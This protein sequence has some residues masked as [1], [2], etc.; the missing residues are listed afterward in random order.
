[1]K[2]RNLG[3]QNFRQIGSQQ[4]RHFR[5]LREDQGPLPLLR[6]LGQDLDEARQLPGPPR[7][8]PAGGQEVLGVVADLLEAG[9]GAQDLPSPRKAGVAFDPLQA[10]VHGRLVERGLLDG[11]VAI[12]PRLVFLWQIADDLRVGLEPAQDERPDEPA[13]FFGRLRILGAFHGGRERPP[14]RAFGTEETRVQDLHDGP[15]VGQAILERSAGERKA[16]GRPEPAYRPRLLGSRILQVLRLVHDEAAPLHVAQLIEVA[17]GD[18]EGTHH[19][20]ALLKRP[21]QVGAARPSRALADVE[22]QRGCEA[23]GFLPPVGDDGVGTHE[24]PRPPQP[25]RLLLSQQEGQGLTGLSQSHVV[26]ETAAEAVVRQ[27]AQ[28]AIADTLVRPELRLQTGWRIERSQLLRGGLKGVEQRPDPGLALD[29]GQD[30]HR[31]LRLEEIGRRRREAQPLAKR[32]AQHRGPVRVRPAA[33]RLREEPVHRVLVEFHPGVA[34]PHQAPFAAGQAPEI[35]QRPGVVVDRDL[36]GIVHQR[37]EADAAVRSGS[38]Q[39]RRPYRARDRTGRVGV[40]PDGETEGRFPSAPSGQ[41][42]RNA[43]LEPLARQRFLPFVKELVGLGRRYPDLLG[44]RALE[45]ALEQR[46]GARRASQVL[47]KRDRRVR[48]PEAPEIRRRVA[49]V[50][51]FAERREGLPGGDRA[52]HVRRSS[53]GIRRNHEPEA[54]PPPERVG[55]GRGSHRLRL[56]GRRFEQEDQSGASDDSRIRIRRTASER[57]V[58]APECL[59]ALAV[60]STGSTREEIIENA[61]DHFPPA[62]RR[63]RPAR[64]PA[65]APPRVSNDAVAK[66]HQVAAD[67]RLGIQ[68]AEGRRRRREPQRVEFPLLGTEIRLPERGAVTSVGVN[69]GAEAAAGQQPQQ[70]AAGQGPETKRRRPEI[71]IAVARGAGGERGRRIERSEGE[72]RTAGIRRAGFEGG[73]FHRG[74]PPVSHPPA[75]PRGEVVGRHAG[76]PEVQVPGGRQRGFE[77]EGRGRA[78]QNR[79][80]YDS[81]RPVV[82]AET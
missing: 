58:R 62:R 49:S 8:E 79:P 59:R 5:E 63:V 7:Q 24:K 19:E 75:E 39:F 68:P 48:N 64:R 47:E 57:V 9:Q 31:L 61:L 80:V 67:G 29:L 41:G 30:L 14:E 55:V 74:R 73:G 23:L 72:S 21:R 28:P 81:L 34:R 35:V 18:P 78:G 44:A 2:H 65:Q 11:E 43:N 33:R 77:T 70:E 16:D 38:A 37:V 54:D 42:G 20:V 56:V 60:Q 69:R 50:P 15:E 13:E 17:V 32:V 4:L 1:M 27:E 10:L 25:A 82:Q 76:R 46:A 40:R 6:D 45:A 51:D 71:G 52:G 22:A 53:A 12:D 26:R 36:P 66:R 3:I